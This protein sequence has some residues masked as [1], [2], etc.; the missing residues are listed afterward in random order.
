MENPD[1]I[2][3]LDE[4]RCMVA[5]SLPP[6]SPNCSTMDNR[7]FIAF[8]DRSTWTLPDCFLG[9]FLFI[10]LFFMC[11]FSYC[12]YLVLDVIPLF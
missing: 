2:S 8:G 5:R 3:S 11:S 1:I 9:L 4:A 10:V 12:Q 6:G 7:A